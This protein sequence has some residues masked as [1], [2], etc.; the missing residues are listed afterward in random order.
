MRIV[1]ANPRTNF[2]EIRLTEKNDNGGI[3]PCIRSRDF[4][5]PNLVIDYEEDTNQHGEGWRRIY[6]EDNLFQSECGELLP[7]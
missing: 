4:K 7:K 5:D 1:I 2:G 3:A 6:T